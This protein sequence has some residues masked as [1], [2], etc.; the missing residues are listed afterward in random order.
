VET[1]PAAAEPPANEGGDSGD[2]P[3]GEPPA[4]ALTV[5]PDGIVSVKYS[6]GKDASDCPRTGVIV[7]VQSGY[8]VTVDGGTAELQEDG[9]YLVTPNP[10][11]DAVTISAVTAT[12]TAKTLSADFA[13]YIEYLS[14]CAEKE[15]SAI[16][17]GFTQ[18]AKSEI[19]V[20]TESTYTSAMIYSILVGDLG[21]N[22]FDTWAAAQTATTPDQSGAQAP[23]DG[24]PPEMPDGE[25]PGEKPGEQPGGDQSNGGGSVETVMPAE[26]APATW[27]GYQQYLFDT[28][29]SDAP[30]KDELKAQIDAL[31]SWDDFDMTVSPWDQ[32][33][34]EGG[35]IYGVALTW[36]EYLDAVGG[37]DAVTPPAADPEPVTYTW[38]SSDPAIATVEGDGTN[39]TVTGIAVGTVVI[40]VTD[41]NGA[42]ASK[43]ITVTDEQ[44]NE[45]PVIAPPKPEQPTVSFSDV[46]DGDWFYTAVQ[47]AASNGIV[48][49][50]E[51]GSFQPN[52]SITRAEAAKMIVLANGLTVDEN[53]APTFKDVP[54]DHWAKG[55]IAAAQQAGFMKGDDNGNFNADAFMTRAELAA[56]ISQTM[57][58]TST[59][60][61]KNFPDVPANEWYANVVALASAAGYVQGDDMGNYN[62]TNNVTRAEFAQVIYNIYLAK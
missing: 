22:D 56:L 20:L 34:V 4:N 62:P 12:P 30:D 1:A 58:L 10:G 60:G 46:K 8:T 43:T 39:A 47:A 26:G 17:A 7:T 59:A 15:W 54:A 57:N 55:Y 36:A 9:T 3:T 61:A 41:S 29:S 51:D 42:T 13:G 28:V 44:T 18:S 31:T 35:F 19:S 48:N 24:Q 49:G 52:G 33:F 32:I 6:D 40:T 25:Q 50:Y 53:A 21:Y 23:T 11:P 45:P 38:T 14:S 5:K 16:D 37:G 27:E 2:A